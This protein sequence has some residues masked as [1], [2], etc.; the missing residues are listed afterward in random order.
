M[1]SF[2]EI[3]K[4]LKS[5]FILAMGCTEPIAVALASAKASETLGKKPTKLKV[6]VSSGV[7][8]NSA[9]VQVPNSGGRKGVRDAAIV[10]ALCGNASLDLEVLSKITDSDLKNIEGNFTS[11]YCQ[12]EV[13]SNYEK[14][15]IK[16]I[17]YSSKGDEASAVIKGAHNN[18]T[19]V[20]KNGKIIFQKDE[21]N[22]KKNASSFSVSVDHI[23]DYLE[24]D[25]SKEMFEYVERQ[26]DNNMAMAVYALKSDS[27]N[28]GLNVGRTLIK[29]SDDI[30]TKAKAYAAAASDARMAGCA[31]PAGVMCG[32]GN[33]G[34]TTSV[35]IAIYGEYK[36]HSKEKIIKSILLT[37]MVALYI[38]CFIGKLSPFCGIVT[39]STGVSAGL[40]YLLG[41]N[42]EQIKNAINIVLGNISGMFCD[43]AK[44]SCA[45]KTASGLDAAFQGAFLAL[46]GNSIK[47]HE[48]I[49]DGEYVEATIKNVIEVANNGMNNVEKVI[50]D[51]MTR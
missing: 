47:G 39:A 37:D 50:C 38:K 16:T 49:V 3:N 24:S 44:A 20:E 8:K 6:I 27:P 21:G 51:I 13:D 41:G 46:D 33:Q 5:E 29:Y 2:E 9:G 19:T 42:R 10:G 7:L 18:I 1:L 25:N 43:G 48:G 45:S 22:N 14:V 28:F 36:K 17:A 34:I 23:L 15:H 35:A 4:F 12:V 11:D 31:M 30:I 26:L 32:S 40:V